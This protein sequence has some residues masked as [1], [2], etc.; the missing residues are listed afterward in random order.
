MVAQLQAGQEIDRYKVEWVLGEGGMAS[1]FRVRHVTLGTT[2]A[3]KVLS[4]TTSD[5]RQRLI[6]EGQMQAT[7]QHPNIVSVSDVID[8]QG[9]P[10][11]LMEYIEGP[12]IDQWTYRYRPTLPEAL[13]VFR[14]IVEGVG[15][16]HNNGL[17]HRDIKP[18]N[19]LLHVGRESIIPK[20]T[21]FGLAKFAQM[22]SSPKRTQ[23]GTTMGTP[24]YMAPEQMRDASKVDHRADLFSLG[25]I[26]YE[27]I[28]GRPPF[29]GNDLV[30]LINT[31]CKGDYVPIPQRV[32]NVPEAVINTVKDLLNPDVLKRIDSCD[33]ILARLEPKPSWV[34][35]ND[36]G[37]LMDHAL[38]TLMDGGAN[39][40]A[41]E[42]SAA[43]AISRLVLENR[44]KTLPAEQSRGT[45][46]DSLDELE[47]V[48]E[49]SQQSSVAQQR[50]SRRMV[51]SVTM[52]LAAIAALLGAA[53]ATFAVAAMWVSIQEE[54]ELVVAEERRA[55]AKES[56]EVATVAT[57]VEPPTEELPVE[58][59]VPSL[60]VAPSPSPAVT[61]SSPVVA[62]EPAPVLDAPSIAVKKT[63]EEAPEPAAAVAPPP[64]VNTPAPQPVAATKEAPKKEVTE[65]VA[66]PKKVKNLVKDLT[67]QYTGAE[68]VVLLSKSGARYE[69]G[70]LLEPGSYEIWARFEGTAEIHAGQAIARSGEGISLRCVGALLQCRTR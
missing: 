13:A 70:Q 40:L 27:L 41:L 10:G 25:C 16:A 35:I 17:I 34:Q 15:H 56:G 7:L 24:Q 66:A 55:L 61:L 9:V 43:K 11:L 12:S 30:E 59:T 23:P 2:H 49:Q 36:A 38:D 29:E 4:I 5:I 69:P 28:C 53:L 54:A 8:I 48:K 18:G 44:D 50:F 57:P 32:P 3:L 26:L 22:P 46:T 52:V 64:P 62:P 67:F 65:I 42:S 51:W 21:D 14:G 39:S 6:Q 45:W 33:E 31:V 37:G 19:I 20:V 68:S 63:V 47:P 1:V 58:A 60:E